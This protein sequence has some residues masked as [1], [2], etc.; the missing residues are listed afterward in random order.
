MDVRV[1]TLFLFSFMTAAAAAAVACGGGESQPAG[2]PPPAAAPVTNPVDAGTAA[3]ITG[4]V[5]LEGKPPA[6]Q[7]INFACDD[8]CVKQTAKMTSTFVVDGNGLQN[9]FVY[10]T[11]GPG[12]VK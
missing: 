4:T 2:T 7:P 12:D 5:V 6:R 3:T 1:R 10:D 9:V 8:Y 11:D